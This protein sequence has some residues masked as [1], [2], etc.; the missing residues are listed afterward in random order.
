MPSDGLCERVLV[1]SML[2]CAINNRMVSAMAIRMQELASGEVTFDELRERHHP[3]PVAGAVLDHWFPN[4]AGKDRK[5]AI[6]GE[7][8]RAAVAYP[9]VPARVRLMISAASGRADRIAPMAQRHEVPIVTVI[10]RCR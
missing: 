1:A 6:P 3:E 10:A 9:L 2:A 5:V 4:L 8:R 7:Q